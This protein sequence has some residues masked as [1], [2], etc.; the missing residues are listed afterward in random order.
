MWLEGVRCC[1]DYN[2]E[3]ERLFSAGSPWTLFIWSLSLPCA[4]SISP[5][6]NSPNSEKSTV[7]KKMI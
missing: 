6:G 7:G 4:D 2:S 3:G 5:Q 1:E